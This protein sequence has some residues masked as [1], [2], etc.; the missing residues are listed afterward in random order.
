MFA[1]IASYSAVCIIAINFQKK[2]NIPQ[3]EVFCII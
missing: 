3:K 1:K 2:Y